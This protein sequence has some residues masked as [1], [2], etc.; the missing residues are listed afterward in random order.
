MKNGKQLNV[1]KGLTNVRLLAGAIFDFKVASQKDEEGKFDN[2]EKFAEKVL[3][4]LFYLFVVV[5]I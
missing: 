2:S 5:D 1:V 3:H 4:L